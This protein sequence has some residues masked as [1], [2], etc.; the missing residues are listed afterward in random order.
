L[1][2]ATRNGGANYH[3]SGLDHRKDKKQCG[4]RADIK[5][6]VPG[7]NLHELKKSAIQDAA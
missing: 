6:Q 1:T 2:S 3:A 7:M 4:P 5:L